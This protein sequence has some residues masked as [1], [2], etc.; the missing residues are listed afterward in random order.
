VGV[1]STAEWGWDMFDTANQYVNVCDNSGLL[2]FICFLAIIV[3]GFKFVGRARKMTAERKKRLFFWALGASLF[4]NCI[5]FVGVSY[6]DQMQAV[7]YALLAVI[8][9][10]MLTTSK[11]EPATLKSRLDGS[12]GEDTNQP[13]HADDEAAASLLRLQSAH[14]FFTF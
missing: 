8:S 11:T 1:K 2:P 14:T 3:Y 7:W 10:A 12:S 6:W 13:T 5:A 4:A 9:A